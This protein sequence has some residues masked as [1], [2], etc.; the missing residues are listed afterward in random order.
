M[1]DFDTVFNST[2][3]DY[4]GV[5][6]PPD[7]S[8]EEN[9]NVRLLSNLT[10]DTQELNVIP[11]QYTEDE[12][13]IDSVIDEVKIKRDIREAVFELM[14]DNFIHGDLHKKNWKKSIIFQNTS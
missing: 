9:E 6:L 7:Y 4:W 11:N 1:G 14:Y 10:F 13:Q 3:M 8:L 5:E 12:E 2:V